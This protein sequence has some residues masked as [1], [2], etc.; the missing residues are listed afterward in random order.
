MRITCPNC[1]AQYEVDDALIPE[2]G[3]DVQCSSCGKGWFQSRQVA[4]AETASAPAAV[5]QDTAP[6]T[7]DEPA[8]DPPHEPVAEADA[9]YETAHD[10]TPE[11][12][13]DV[14]AE[15]DLAESAEFEPE[16][17]HSPEVGLAA[18]SEAE[19]T[20]DEAPEWLRD[21]DEPTPAD[22]P[23]PPTEGLAQHAEGPAPD[24][25]PDAEDDPD[26]PPA[27]A[28][29]LP[30]R[31]TDET[32]LAVLREEAEREIAQRRQ[33]AAT[34][35]SQPDLGLPEAPE[36]S[37]GHRPVDA[38]EVGGT[39]QREILP[40]IDA[41]NSSLR[42]DHDRRDS[43]DGETLV[44]EQR[45][46]FRMGF[47]IMLAIAAALI[48]LYVGAD[49]LAETVPALAPV[50]AAYLDLANGLRSWIDGLLAAGVDGLSA[51]VPPPADV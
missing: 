19:L 8:D 20:I 10:P 40:D 26:A 25:E 18:A 34:L 36:R 32:I 47:G 45:R 22:A 6:E 48:A 13:P 14:S 1:G 11:T 39:R 21:T 51:L 44:E 46:G 27:T 31:K 50:L 41:I 42:S 9:A 16:A 43:L 15:A 37:A 7:M 17:D 33:E 35:E 2:S 29:A 30:P 4:L 49:W 5:T 24:A 12:A 23:E 38:A 28:A 3:R